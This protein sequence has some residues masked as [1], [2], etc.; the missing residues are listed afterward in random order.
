MHLGSLES[1]Q[2]VRV[3]RVALGC[4]LE[5]FCRAKQ[6]GEAHEKVQKLEYFSLFVQV[7]FQCSARFSGKKEFLSSEYFREVTTKPSNCTLSLSFNSII[8]I[9][10]A[11]RG[12]K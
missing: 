4:R 12:S 7:V 10:I 8:L 3:V 11:T 5:L 1:T 2:E 6:F 9:R